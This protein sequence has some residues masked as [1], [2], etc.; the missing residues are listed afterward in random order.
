MPANML[1]NS[2]QRYLA[3]S[4][5]D[6][7]TTQDLGSITVKSLTE[8]ANVTRQ[9]FYN[10]FKNMSKLITFTSFFPDLDIASDAPFEEAM[11]TRMQFNLQHKDFFVQL[12]NLGEF[13]ELWQDGLA[14][15]AE[16]QRRR[17]PPLPQAELER[18]QYR[19]DLFTRC[20][21][22]VFHQWWEEGMVTPVDIVM[23]ELMDI[24]RIFCKA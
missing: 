2:T 11:R 15:L 19:D 24:A 13:N 16:I 17:E 1:S 21:S 8:Y 14:L 6:L 7:C 3:L 20:T 23:E 5:M 12:S 10:H 22:A 18:K 4:L 9:T